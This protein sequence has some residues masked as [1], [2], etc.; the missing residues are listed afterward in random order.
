MMIK[1]SWWIKTDYWVQTVL[2]VSILVT[3]ASMIG[4]FLALMLLIPLGGWQ[5][6]S[7]LIAALK[8]ERIQQIYLGVVVAY[9]C[10]WYLVPNLNAF[11]F[12][13]MVII[14]LVI[15]VWKYTVVRADYISLKIIDARQIDTNDFLDA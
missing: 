10:F 2:G 1:N 14:P 7:G 4:L 5:V 12:T 15:G 3:A 11:F 9:G 13:L 6:I 8:G